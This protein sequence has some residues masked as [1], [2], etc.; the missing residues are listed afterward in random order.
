MDLTQLLRLRISLAMTV[1]SFAF[2][3]TS[4]HIRQDNSPGFGGRGGTPVCEDLPEGLQEG[5]VDSYVC[6][7]L[8][9]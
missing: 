2:P 4:G 5:M 3:Y 8:T 6:T 7:A 1:S 9:F